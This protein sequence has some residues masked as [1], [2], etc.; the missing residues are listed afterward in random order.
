MIAVVFNDNHA[1]KTLTVHSKNGKNF[2]RKVPPMG[3]LLSAIFFP[4]QPK[5]KHGR[6]ASQ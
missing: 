2:P 3:F 5:S 4:P 6:A 1:Q